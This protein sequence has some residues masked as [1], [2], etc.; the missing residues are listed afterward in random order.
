MDGG[1]YLNPMFRFRMCWT[2]LFLSLG[3][4]AQPD[5]NQR[6]A[7]FGYAGLNLA[8]IDG[9]YYFGYNKAGIRFG[10]GAHIVIKPKWYTSV[11]LGFNQLGTRPSRKERN[12]RNLAT[13]DL[14]LNV[15]EVPVLLH[16]RLG[17]KNAY[18]KKLNYQLYRSSEI[19]FGLA[20]SRT[21]GT[22]VERTGRASQFAAREDFVAVQ[23]QYKSTDL[24]F[25]LGV[26][27]Q[28][29]TSSSIY[30]QHGKSVLG[31]YRPETKRMGEVLPLFPYYFNLGMRYTL[32]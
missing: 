18:T 32:Y 20:V 14:R 24:Y 11:G 17:D 5:P 31:I 9:D 7:A 30:V 23:D 3:L 4:A 13:I 25:L 21:V 22:R 6:F 10:V 12:E 27:V 19:Q 29:S 1:P 8:Q 16:Y 2:A 26:A 15:V 28:L